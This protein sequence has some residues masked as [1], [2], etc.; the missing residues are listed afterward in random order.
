MY[1]SDKINRYIYITLLEFVNIVL[2]N[3]NSKKDLHR[4]CK[5]RIIFVIFVS[6]IE[7]EEKNDI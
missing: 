3:S 2:N 6:Q 7:I 1:N 4:V 5:N